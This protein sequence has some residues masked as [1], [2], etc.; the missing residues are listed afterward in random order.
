M[1]MAQLPWWAA[2]WFVYV[3][4]KAGPLLA[5]QSK[6]QQTLGRLLPA[7]SSQHAD[8]LVSFATCLDCFLCLPLALVVSAPEPAGLAGV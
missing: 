3:Q 8:P 7:Q 1:V 4:Q 6:Q 2:L 5:A